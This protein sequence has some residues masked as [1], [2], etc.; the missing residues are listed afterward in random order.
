MPAMGS[1]GGATPEGQVE[2]LSKL[3]ITP[4]TVGSPIHSSM[5]VDEIGRL[6]NGAAVYVDRIALK[7]DG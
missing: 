4:E 3:G 6:D 1:H 2:V 7:A 5:E